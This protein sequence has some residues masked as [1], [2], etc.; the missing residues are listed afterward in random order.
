M[1]KPSIGTGGEVVAAGGRVVDGKGGEGG[2]DL[3]FGEGLGIGGDELGL[4]RGE[5]EGK[6]LLV[7]GESDGPEMDIGHGDGALSIE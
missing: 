5:V 7:V 6:A 2:I 4:C 1:P 3:R